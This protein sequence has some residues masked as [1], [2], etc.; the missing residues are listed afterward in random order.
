MARF[1]LL[2]IS[3][4]CHIGSYLSPSIILSLFLSLSFFL[5]VLWLGLWGKARHKALS[6]RDPYGTKLAFWAFCIY[7]CH[8]NNEA[9]V[10]AASIS[11]L[12]RQG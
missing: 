9:F 1:K 7:A 4:L 3:A 6:L 11:E 5:V 2:I 12:E 10:R 8:A